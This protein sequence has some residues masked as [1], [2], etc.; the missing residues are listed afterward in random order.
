MKTPHSIKPTTFLLQ[1]EG[2]NHHTTMSSVWKPCSVIEWCR[3]ILTN[4]RLTG[5]L[6]QW[7]NCC[8]WRS[9][10][11]VSSLI[12]SVESHRVQRWAA[13]G[14]HQYQQSGTVNTEQ[15]DLCESVLIQSYEPRWKEIP[16]T[17][18]QH[19]EDHKGHRG[20][21]TGIKYIGI[22]VQ[23]KKKCGYIAV[24]L[25]QLVPL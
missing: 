9:R 4:C 1:G 24:I 5:I 14:D 16:G 3:K 21:T 13:R 10:I 11:C 20:H 18:P 6:H 15:Y 19:G 12:T 23:N 8:E 22:V 25:V 17:L 7:A 2:D